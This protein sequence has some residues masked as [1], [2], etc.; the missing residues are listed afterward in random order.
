M[1]FTSSIPKYVTKNS[2]YELKIV[3][4]DG[5]ECIYLFK[6]LRFKCQCAQCKHEL[7]GEKLIKIEDVPNEINLL[8]CEV[9]GNYAL[10]FKWSDNHSTGIYTYDYLRSLCK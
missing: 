3:W 5:K 7:T 8:A 10:N 1:V 2:P 4:N 6:D 9:V